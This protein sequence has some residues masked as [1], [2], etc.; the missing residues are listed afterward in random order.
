MKK[1]KLLIDASCIFAVISGV[2]ESDIIYKKT[3][4]FELLSNECLPFE[5][6]NVISKLIKRDL[7]SINQGLDLYEQFKNIQLIYVE[8]DF[9]KVIDIAG[10]EKHYSYDILYLEN[11]I[12]L[13]IPLLTL[14]KSLMAIAE[15]RGVKCL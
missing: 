14:D 5:I 11:A 15:R 8:S 6:C 3:E 12:K 7:I 9:R 4:G 1:K 10:Q 2:K 13:G